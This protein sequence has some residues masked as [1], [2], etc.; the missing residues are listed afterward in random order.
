[1]GSERSGHGYF[2]LKY[3]PGIRL[4]KHGETMKNPSQDSWYPD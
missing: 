3:N 1:M 2:F 4:E